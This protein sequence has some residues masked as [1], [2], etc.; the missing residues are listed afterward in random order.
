MAEQRYRFGGPIPESVQT[1]QRKRRYRDSESFATL[2]KN[3]RQD[4]WA[5]PPAG[6]E[7]VHGN[8]GEVIGIRPTAPVVMANCETKECACCLEV[9]MLGR[10]LPTRICTAEACAGCSCLTSS[11]AADADPEG[12]S[13]APQLGEL[14]PEG[15]HPTEGQEP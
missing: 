6:W 3:R 11:A 8:W 13:P 2:K 14:S 5:N 9:H 10:E 12:I 7:Q 15:S 1:L 4:F